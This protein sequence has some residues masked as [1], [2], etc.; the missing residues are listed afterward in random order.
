MARHDDVQRPAQRIE[1]ER[2]AV[3]GYAAAC[4]R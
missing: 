1:V 4:W 3:D 2:A